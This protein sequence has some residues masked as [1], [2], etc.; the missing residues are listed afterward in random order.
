MLATAD[1]PGDTAPPFTS[2]DFDGKY[3]RTP[4]TVRLTADDVGGEVA[5]TEYRIDEG[6]EWLPYT[7]PLSFDAPADHTGDGRHELHYRSTDTHGNVGCDAVI[8]VGIDTLGPST[9]VLL[10]VTV[11]RGAGTSIAV[12]VS[13]ATSPRARLVLRFTRLSDG[14]TASPIRAEVR[15]NREQTL[16]FRCR[17]LP[18]RYRLTLEA[19]D[20]AGNRQ[21]H[22]GRGLLV[23]R[24]ARAG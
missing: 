9:A 6:V 4:V 15:T 10:P 8:E 7:V 24:P 22:A 21:V 19:T 12:R 5:S 16:R 18:G 1:L 20:L 3:H 11:M 17:L 2:H 14:R 23:V 13:D